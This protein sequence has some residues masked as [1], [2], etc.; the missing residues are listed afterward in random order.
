MYDGQE[1]VEGMMFP[2]VLQDHTRGVL[3]ADIDPT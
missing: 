3:A 2:A 1:S